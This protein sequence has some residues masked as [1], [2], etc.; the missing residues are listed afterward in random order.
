MTG[1]EEE[2]RRIRSRPRIIGEYFAAEKELL[3]PGNRWEPYRLIDPGGVPVEAV[4][5]YFRYLKERRPAIDYS[6]LRDPNGAVP[7]V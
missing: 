7:L 5:A 1:L 3:K 4:I 2:R 6:A